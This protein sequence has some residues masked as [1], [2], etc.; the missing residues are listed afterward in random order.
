MI[1]L[2]YVTILRSFNLKGGKNTH[3]QL[4]LFDIAVTLK[5]GQYHWK[6][7]ERVKVRK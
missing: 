6:W 1:Y 4:T 3:F 2:K 5:Y 7:C